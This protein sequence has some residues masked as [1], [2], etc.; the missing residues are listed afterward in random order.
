MV[1]QQIQP[2][3]IMPHCLPHLA[4]PGPITGITPQCPV[5]TGQI[6]SI[7]SVPNATTYTWTVPAGWTITSGQGTISITVN[8]GAAGQNGNISVTAGN[9]CGTSACQSF[10]S[11][12]KSECSYYL[13]YRVESTLYWRN[14]CLYCQRS[15][16][17]WGYRS[18]EQQQSC[19]SHG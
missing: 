18:M 2:Q 12:S 17:W 11:Y 4:V 8:T 15:S 6:Y 13:S 5:L 14:I 7:V 3:L 19:S 10:S 1:L 9:S 16:S